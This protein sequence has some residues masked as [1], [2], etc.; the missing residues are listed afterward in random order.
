M[1]MHAMAGSV[2]SERFEIVNDEARLGQIAAAWDELWERADGLVFQS[3]G[4]ITAWWRS[5]PDRDRRALRIGLV[6]NGERL[7]AV[8]AL[9]THRRRGVQFLEWA[10][11]S[12]SDYEDILSDPN[13]P[14]QALE[15]LWREMAG[16][17]GFDV[18]LINRL[19]PD[20]QA[21]RLLDVPAKAKLSL[22]Y[23]SEVAHC[24]TG[25]WP[26]GA[27][28]FDSQNKKARQNY[29]RGQKAIGE[30]GTLSFRVLAADEP[31]GPVLERLAALK[32]NWLAARGHSSELFAED[33][34]TLISLVEFLRDKGILRLFVLELDGLVVAAS[35]NF[36]QRGTLMAFVTTY[37]PAFERGSP[38]TL[39]INDYIMWAFD[40]GLGTVDF[41]C[42]AEAFKL[43]FAT[44]TRTLTCLVGAGSWRGRVAVMA[45]QAKHKLALWRK[46]REKTPAATPAD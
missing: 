10:A 8:M 40:H 15:R 11:N 41:L 16:H 5:V 1:N 20:A 19:R 26:N 29:R 33:G 28:W 38:G 27:A 36:V 17:G 12:H 44:E 4:W 21:K 34:Q 31:P 13:C 25:D 24:V 14:T 43:R 32:R 46:N 3:H 18:A 22:N 39:L 2:R 9:A 23:R 6:W 42:G 30:T 45:D 37:D 35:V 7:D